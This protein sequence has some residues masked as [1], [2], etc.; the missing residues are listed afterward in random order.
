MITA[1]RRHRHAVLG[2][3]RDAHEW[4][5]RRFTDEFKTVIFENHRNEDSGFLHRKTLSDTNAVTHAKGQ[6]LKPIN[7]AAAVAD[8]AR[9]IKCGRTLP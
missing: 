7:R 1:R 3:Y 2:L 8:E 5:W 9:W 6:V 4:P